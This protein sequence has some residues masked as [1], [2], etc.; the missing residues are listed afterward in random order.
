M[1]FT[2]NHQ[3]ILRVPLSVS[4]RIHKHQKGSHKIQV[5]AHSCFTFLVFIS[6]LGCWVKTSCFGYY[7]ICC[8]Q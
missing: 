6:W 2:K 8:G 1:S 7:D 3:G 5:N 4:R